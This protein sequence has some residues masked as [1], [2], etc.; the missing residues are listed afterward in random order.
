[1]IVTLVPSLASSSAKTR[2]KLVL[3]EPVMPKMAACHSTIC[4]AV[5]RTSPSVSMFII[6]CAPFSAPFLRMLQL[7]THPSGDLFLRD[8]RRLL[9]RLGSQLAAQLNFQA[10]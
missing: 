1:M 6:G 10:L 8:R 3:P 5:G 7:V 2:M 4:W 9:A